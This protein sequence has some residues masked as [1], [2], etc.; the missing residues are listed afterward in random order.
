MLL[1]KAGEEIKKEA[2]E[3]SSEKTKY[4]SSNVKDLELNLDHEAL[5]E[6]CQQ[7]HNQLMEVEAERFDLEVVVR[8]QDMEV[9]LNW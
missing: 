7:L 9:S 3:R 6:L 2:E 8:R 1:K 5:E 4:I